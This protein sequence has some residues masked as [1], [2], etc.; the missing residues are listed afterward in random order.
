[1]VK[2]GIEVE[3][4]RSGDPEGGSE[5]GSEECMGGGG[6]KAGHGW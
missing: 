3:G 1:M 4:G 2:E 6:E 5:V